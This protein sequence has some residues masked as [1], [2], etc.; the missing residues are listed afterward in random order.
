MKSDFFPNLGR[1]SVV[2]ILAILML[3]ACAPAYGAPA[4]AY[5]AQPSSPYSA[6]GPAGGPNTA[7][8]MP[9]MTP[10]PAPQAAGPAAPVAS[11]TAGVSIENLAFNPGAITV[12]IGTTVV[13]ANN[14]Q[15]QEPHTVTSGTASA[16]SGLFDSGILTPGQIFQFKFNSPGTFAYFC[17]VHGAAMTGTVTVVP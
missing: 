16:P 8:T 5:G 1:I 17:R 11:G 6:S 10:A 12:H 14:E 3:T 9:D 4:S 7:P 2:A 15:D 13:W